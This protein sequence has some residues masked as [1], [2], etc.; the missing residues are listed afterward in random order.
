MLNSFTNIIDQQH[1]VAIWYKHLGKVLVHCYFTLLK[2]RTEAFL[3]DYE[4]LHPL[5]W[6]TLARR[7]LLICLSLEDSSTTGTK[8]F[9]NYL[10]VFSFHANKHIILLAI[11]FWCISIEFLLP[12]FKYLDVLIVLFPC[13]SIQSK[14]LAVT[15]SYKFV[16]GKNVIAR[17]ISTKLEFQL[18]RLLSLVTVF[19]RG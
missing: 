10:I 9:R 2:R 18:V 19:K 16:A 7:V 5:V 15:L 13:M 8:I 1:L 3:L 4:I 14:S 12:G 6:N 11:K 17:F